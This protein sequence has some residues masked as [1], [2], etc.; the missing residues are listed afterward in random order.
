MP[1]DTI[2]GRLMP[3]VED[4]FAALE[5]DGV[6]YC[7]LRNDEFLDGTPVG[8]DIDV[9]IPDSQ[10][11]A[12]RSALHAVG[13]ETA[14]RK[15]TNRTYFVNL[16]P[17]DTTR[18]ILHVTWG[19]VSYCGLPITQGHR[20]LDSRVRHPSAPVWIPSQEGKYVQLVFHSILNRGAYKQKYV[21]ELTELATTVDRS[22]LYEH[23][24]ELFGRAGRSVIDLSL[25]G[26]FDAT[27]EYKWQLVRAGLTR[28]PEAIPRFLYVLFVHYQLGTAMRRLNRQ[29]N[30]CSPPP[31]IVLIGPDGAGKT[32]V[33]TKL[34]KEFE[35]LDVESRV[36]ELGV[37]NGRSRPI[38]LLQRL[39]TT[40]GKL[41]RSSDNNS[42]GDGTHS[43]H[44][45]GALTLESR[46][47]L[48]KSTVYLLDQWYRLLRANMTDVD[49]LI[50]DRHIHDVVLYHHPSVHQVVSLFESEQVNVF[51]L[52]AETDVIAARSEYDDQGVE[53]L[54]QRL[55]VLSHERVD[56]D[57]DPESVAQTILSKLADSDFPATL[58]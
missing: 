56:V 3:I 2:R 35:E 18:V 54:Q 31:T 24:T 30:P 51:V 13:F 9:L 23:A 49:V 11:K 25:A 41:F 57:G 7:L 16:D 58:R 27:L 29:W 21:D 10:R 20:L 47:G 6:D 46:N 4:T 44:E 42:E 22:E 52:D 39:N 38:K 50:A 48:L 43:P 55:A 32:T 26:E 45:G 28:H 8:N 17:A 15:P 34:Q 37:Y 36:E 5:D 14:K 33:A 19:D 40:V 1:V 12:A 53:E